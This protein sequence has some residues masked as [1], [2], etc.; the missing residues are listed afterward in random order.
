[1]M[2]TRITETEIE[3]LNIPKERKKNQDSAMPR[4]R[5]IDITDLNMVITRKWRLQRAS[6]NKKIEGTFQ[7]NPE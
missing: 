4:I 7:I 2:E 3:L 6:R 5:D 1:M